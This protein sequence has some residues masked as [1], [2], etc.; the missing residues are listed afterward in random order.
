M[1]QLNKHRDRTFTR[2]SACTNVYDQSTTTVLGRQLASASNCRTGG[3]CINQENRP[4]PFMPTRHIGKLYE[5]VNGT[6][7]LPQPPTSHTPIDIILT[8]RMSE[9]RCSS[10]S[11]RTLSC[12]KHA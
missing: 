11:F 2:T 6:S 7:L 9:E 1:I 4:Y 3:S 12:V 10:V 5:L 8:S